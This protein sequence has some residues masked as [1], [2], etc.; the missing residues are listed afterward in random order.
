MNRNLITLA[1][2]AGLST[3]ALASP[4]G[5]N[6]G[7][8]G[9]CGNGQTTNGCGTAPTTNHGGAGGTGVG[10]GIGIASAKGG[11]ASA[12]GGK[13]YSGSASMASSNQSAETGDMNLDQGNTY[14]APAPSFTV[15]P[16]SSGGIV[17][18]SHA[19]SL[20]W[21]LVSWSKS[22]Q[23]TDPF[24]GGMRLVDDLESACQFESAS[25]LR[26]HMSALLFPSY[27]ELPAQPGVV[28]LTVEQ[29]AA[30]RK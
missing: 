19:V 13:S 28:N 3:V 16:Q 7:G 8:N 11:N 21:N 23:T 2:L 17:T 14:V 15:I 29:C 9:G 30:R 22:E 5:N 27:R 18:K 12:Q 10:V 24:Q 4:P 20:G 25:M 6:G 1:L 26:Q